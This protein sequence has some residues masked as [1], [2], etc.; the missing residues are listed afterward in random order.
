MNAVEPEPLYR[1]DPQEWNRH[2]AEGNARQPRKRVG[3]DALIF[4]TSQRIL[5][6]HPTYK[7]GWDLPGGMAEANEPPDT[8]LRRELM[9]ELGLHIPVAGLTL[10]CLDWVPPHEPWDDSLMFIFDAGILDPDQ[11][12]TLRIGDHE[13][14]AFEF[15]TVDIAE[16]RLGPRMKPRVRAALKARADHGVAYLHG[17]QSFTE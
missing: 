4:D 12:G 2:L 6:V 7:P 10:L 17:G 5:L 3:A 9:E 14:D 8:A 15:C 11:I 13:L 1:R 16:S